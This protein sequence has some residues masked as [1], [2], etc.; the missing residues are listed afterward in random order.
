LLRSWY[1]ISEENFT[2]AKT[3]G[4]NSVVVEFHSMAHN[5]DLLHH[6]INDLLILLWL[7]RRNKEYFANYF[8]HMSD[9]TLIS[10]MVHRV[11]LNPGAS[12]W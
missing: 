12:R 11:T 6:G 3:H 7:R 9:V 2:Q 1:W 4:R 5:E 10:Q 8:L